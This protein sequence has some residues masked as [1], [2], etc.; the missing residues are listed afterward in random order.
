[1]IPNKNA[2]PCSLW[3]IARPFINEEQVQLDDDLTVL[4]DYLDY[5]LY[6]YPLKV[7]FIWD[8][9][10]IS[11]DEPDY[12]VIFNKVLYF[13]NDMWAVACNNWIFPDYDSAMKYLLDTTLYRY[14]HIFE[15]IVNGQDTR[16]L[17]SKKALEMFNDKHN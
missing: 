4:D 9:S 15:N 11:K 6:S 17:Q 16:I 5:R 14:K 7:N 8:K 2:V 13:D 1:M 3:T 10:T 12:N